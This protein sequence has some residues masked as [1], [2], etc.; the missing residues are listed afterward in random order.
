MKNWG[1][2][3]CAY[4]G[5]R[6]RTPIWIWLISGPGEGDQ[7]STVGIPQE[8]DETGGDLVLEGL[9]L[10]EHDLSMSGPKGDIGQ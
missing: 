6:N 5:K 3:L 2:F 1:G 4:T 8:F 10:T 9:G 7:Q